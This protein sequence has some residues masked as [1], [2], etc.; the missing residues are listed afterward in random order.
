MSKREWMPFEDL[1]SVPLKNGLTRPKA[2]RGSGV[3]MVNMGE[4]FAH[5]RISDIAM[6]R[7]FLS[8]KEASSFLLE[9]YDLLFARQSLVLAGAGKCSIVLE[10]P[11][12]TTWE[13]HIIR[14]RL[15]PQLAD[16]LF[17]YYFFLSQIGR[18]AMESIVEQVAAAGIRGSD[19][20][21]LK[22]PHPPLSEQRA[23]AHLLGSLDNKIELTRQM[24]ETLEDMARTLFREWFINFGP[25]RAKIEGR[26]PEG[27]APKI[28]ALF[29]D[30]LDVEGKPVGWEMKR[31]DDILELAY[32]KAL[33]ATDR[34]AGDVPVYGSGG[35]TGYHNTFLVKGPSIVVGRKGTVGSLYWEDR[36]FFPIDTVFYVNAKAPLTFC[37]YL[38]Q[39][40]G[41][42]DMNTDAAVPGLNRNNVYRLPVVWP[43]NNLV[44][45]FDQVVS[46]LRQKI[47]ENEL[48]AQSLIQIRNLLLPKLLSGKI[49]LKDTKQVVG[50]LL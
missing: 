1:F 47:F 26:E 6:D 20:A 50:D 32:G 21:K 14:A 36:P 34:I 40:L 7:V 22:V 42:H 4:I 25:V 9:P 44:S 8:E 33:K 16:P 24:N 37:F 12:P 3:K 27:I 17:Y 48:E 30:S 2:V 11:E 29:P 41:L 10:V 13:S 49:Q 23:I 43:S 18:Q 45:M 15:N 39:S 5:S 28:A 46:P 19:L 38:L 35:I 31:V